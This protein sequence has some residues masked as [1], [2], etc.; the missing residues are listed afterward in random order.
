MN[1]L[2]GCVQINCCG[3]TNEH[4]HKG[5]RQKIKRNVKNRKETSEIEKQSC[6]RTQFIRNLCFLKKKRVH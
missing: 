6:V 3:N 4:K 1:I 5:K 2:L